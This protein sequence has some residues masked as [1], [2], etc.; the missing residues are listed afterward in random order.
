MRL[1]NITLSYN[2]NP[3]WTQRIG[4]GGVRLYLA[5]MNLFEVT[6]MRKP[7]DPENLHTNVLSVQNFNGA[8]EYSLQRIFAL[9][10]NITL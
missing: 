6:N 7:L 8:V 9:G 2:F 4:I 3:E 1:K 10:A 5:A